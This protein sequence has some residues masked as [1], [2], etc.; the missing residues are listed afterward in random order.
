MTSRW[1]KSRPGDNPLKFYTAAFY[2]AL[3]D[4]IE[5]VKGQ[6]DKRGA[7]DMI[8]GLDQPSNVVLVQNTTSGALPRFSVVGIDGPVITPAANLLEFQNRFPLQGVTPSAAAHTGK[9]A[10]LLEPAAQGGLARAALGGVVP[11]QIQLQTA[12]PSTGVWT[13]DVADGQTGYLQPVGGGTAEVLWCAAATTSYPATVWAVVRLGNMPMPQLYEIT[14]YVHSGAN[15]S[16]PQWDSTDQIY[17]VWGVPVDETQAPPVL[18]ATAAPEKL[19]LPGIPRDAL[20]WGDNV[21][22]FGRHQRVYT[23]NDPNGRAILGSPLDDQRHWAFADVEQAVPPGS[24]MTTAIGISPAPADYFLTVPQ[25]PAQG[26]YNWPQPPP[27]L[28]SE[29][30]PV[31]N[32]EQ[33]LGTRAITEPI[34]AQLATPSGLVWNRGMACGPANGPAL[35][36]G[37]PGFVLIGLP[38]TIGGTTYGL[39]IADAG[40]SKI[41]CAKSTQKWNSASIPEAVTSQPYLA[42]NPYDAAT[43]YTDSSV[44]IAVSLPV[45]GAVQDYNVQA[46]DVLA[47]TWDAVC[48]GFVALHI[49]GLGGTARSLI[50]AKVGT[51]IVSTTM[52]APAGWALMNGT[53]NSIDNGG[54]GIDMGGR[55][56]RSI[57]A[58]GGI[59]GGPATGGNWDWTYPGP[60]QGTM[61][62]ETVYVNAGDDADTPVAQGQQNS[63]LFYPAW[64]SLYFYER[65]P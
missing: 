15:D 18:S 60:T 50:N 62:L 40:M 46:G 3:V 4:S 5:W 11:V 58:P 55:M 39:V 20:G 27:Y 16:T 57:G 19:Y 24:A 47:Y 29:G 43:G 54:S 33:G 56:L 6:K 21:A 53:A 22:R 2:N 28:I 64:Q 23:Y 10:I 36:P 9:F 34:L 25:P 17:Y 61:N 48:V 12:P 59:G 13:A 26:N 37:L 41:W 45:H 52:I 35:H 51:T 32:H 49:L 30:Q 14:G 8:P 44:T 7:G 38:T 63:A 42:C 65:I 1:L 31:A